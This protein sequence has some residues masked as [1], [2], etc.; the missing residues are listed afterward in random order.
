MYLEALVAV[1]TSAVLV[2]FSGS[3]LV[4]C[5][6]VEVGGGGGVGRERLSVSVLV[7]RGHRRR[8][9]LPGLVHRVQRVL[10]K[11]E[12]LACQGR[13]PVARQSC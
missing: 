5:G 11:S 13:S 9:Q 2:K 8:S 1:G 10:E 4:W 12:A 6:R 7:R 3:G